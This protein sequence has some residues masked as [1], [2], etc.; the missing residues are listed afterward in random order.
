MDGR[1]DPRD[2]R[3]AR[4]PELGDGR[5]DAG[6]AA[7]LP[8]DGEGRP[9]A[10]VGRPHPSALP[11]RRT[12]RRSSPAS[13]SRWPRASRRSARS[14][15]WSASAR[16]WRSSSS[17]SASSSC[18]ARG[19]ICRGRSGCRWCRCC[20]CCRRSSLRADAGPAVDHL[21]AADHLDGDRGRGLL[22]LR[23]SPQPASERERQVRP[24]GAMSI[25]RRPVLLREP[26]VRSSRI[27]HEDTKFSKTTRRRIRFVQREG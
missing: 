21:G 23:L 24:D 18:G 4:R 2:A 10:G 12:S 19:P 26:R 25:G 1:D 9:A 5:D 13:S 7:H 17:R 6:A 22:R 16:C 20:R 8:R 27:Q 15:S 3:R 14:A 11:A